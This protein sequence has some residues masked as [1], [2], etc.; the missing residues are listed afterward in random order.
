MARAKVGVANKSPTDTGDVDD[1]GF[2][3]ADS[4]EACANGARCRS[5]YSVTAND[6]DA[7]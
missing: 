3:G 7:A 5:M 4:L 2:A 1:A 6:A